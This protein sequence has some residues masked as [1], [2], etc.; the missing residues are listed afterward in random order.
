MKI[1]IYTQSILHTHT[2]TQT[3]THTHTHTHTLYTHTCTMIIFVH[4]Y[5][6]YN[7]MFLYDEVESLKYYIL[8]PKLLITSNNY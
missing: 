3:H 8:F 7:T 4:H 6:Q 2:H 5:M 1:H